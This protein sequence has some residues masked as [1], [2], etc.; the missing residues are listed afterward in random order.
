MS[1][2]AL[3]AALA[4]V[5]AALAD[6]DVDAK[7]AAAAL[8]ARL[9]LSSLATVRALV[10]QGVAEGW[11]CDKENAGVR[12]S[13]VLKAAAPTAFSIDAVHMSGPALGHTHPNGEIDLCF[14]VDDA[15]A[16][17]DGQPEGFTVYGKGT[18]H[19][20]T[21]TGGAMDILYFLPG[22]GIVFD[23]APKKA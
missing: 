19:I 17:F 15:G 16:R 1:K 14:C 13:R 7:D 21:V 11:L 9:P 23:G 5:T 8:N 6:V 12:F 18:W 3:L 4:P 22:G 2:D 10:R 20:P